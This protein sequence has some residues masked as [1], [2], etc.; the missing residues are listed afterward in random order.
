MWVSGFE[1]LGVRAR[2][3]AR[4]RVRA[5]KGARVGRHLDGHHPGH[6]GRLLPW[7]VLVDGG[8]ACLGHSK[9]PHAP[10]EHKGHSRLG[11]FELPLS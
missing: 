11:A 5:R 1:P 2:V 6:Q 8:H 4:V 9:A 7:I 3:S 10:V